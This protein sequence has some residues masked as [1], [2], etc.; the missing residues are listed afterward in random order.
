MVFMSSIVSTASSLAM[1][2]SWDKELCSCYCFLI[3]V[4]PMGFYCFLGDMDT[5]LSFHLLQ[6]VPRILTIVG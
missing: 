4:H 1:F 2:F 6:S 5:T 3:S